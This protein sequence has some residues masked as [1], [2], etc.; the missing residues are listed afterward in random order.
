[1]ARLVRFFFMTALGVG[2]GKA[3]IQ[4]SLLIP[5]SKLCMSFWSLKDQQCLQW[6]VSDRRLFQ[7]ILLQDNWHQ[8]RD[9]Q[10]ASSIFLHSLA[11]FDTG[12]ASSAIWIKHGF[13]CKINSLRRHK[14]DNF[15]FLV[16]G[17]TIHWMGLTAKD[18]GF[19]FS[20]GQV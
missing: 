14:S 17:S 6:R 4:L 3:T 15:I 11:L 18:T 8:Y 7:D 10:G 13:V 9:M 1:M 20:L 12:Y 19:L 5:T 16:S 2:I